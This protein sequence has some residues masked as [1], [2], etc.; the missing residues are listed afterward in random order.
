[1]SSNSDESNPPTVDDSLPTPPPRP[2]FVLPGRGGGVPRASPFGNPLGVG[3]SFGKKFGIKLDN[4]FGSLHSFLM[5]EP[6]DGDSFFGEFVS[7]GSVQP[8][9]HEYLSATDLMRK[10]DTLRW[11]IPT[12]N[13]IEKFNVGGGSTRMNVHSLNSVLSL[14][15]AGKGVRFS[16]DELKS[17]EGVVPGLEEDY[18]SIDKLFKGLV[19][20]A[21]KIKGVDKVKLLDDDFVLEEGKLIQGSYRDSLL[22]FSTLTKKYLS[23]YSTLTI[24]VKGKR[25]ELLKQIAEGN[26]PTFDADPEAE[27]KLASPI[28]EYL[29]LL[30]KKYKAEGNPVNSKSG[31]TVDSLS[32]FSSFLSYCLMDMEFL[33]C[34]FNEREAIEELLG[35]ASDGS[36]SERQHEGVPQIIKT[37]DYWKRRIF[38][39]LSKMKE[40]KACPKKEKD[41]ANRWDWGSDGALLDARDKSD[42]KGNAD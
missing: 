40:L 16:T 41:L 30:I 11:H 37:E 9:S 12:V 35:G 27:L 18:I 42:K 38:N 5:E 26:A 21:K 19:A 36:D 8:F 7:G 6:K 28:P 33:V 20:E 34:S 13:E 24:L 3:V 14:C 10:L 39:F 4:N 29:D 31:A 23:S 15:C 17:V 25:Q 32:R 1:M 2:A 22:E